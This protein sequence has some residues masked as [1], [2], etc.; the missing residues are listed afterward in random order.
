ML[1]F[2]FMDIFTCE[3]VPLLGLSQFLLM[4]VMWPWSYYVVV[5]RYVSHFKILYHV[6]LVKRH[7]NLIA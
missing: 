2:F 4:V 5:L 7:L 1:V 3:F 6:C